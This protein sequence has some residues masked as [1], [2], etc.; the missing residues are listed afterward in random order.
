[1]L[2]IVATLLQWLP[3]LCYW[4]LIPAVLI[5]ILLAFVRATRPSSALGLLIVAAVSASLLSIGLVAIVSGYGSAVV[6]VLRT[7]GPIEAISFLPSLFPG[8]GSQLA[9]LLPVAGTTAGSSAAVV[10]LRRTTRRADP[11]AA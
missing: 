3:R 11:A 6:H 8:V 10:V 7:F 5:L 4:V 9:G 1:M 2:Q